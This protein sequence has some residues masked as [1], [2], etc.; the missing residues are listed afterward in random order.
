MKFIEISKD[1]RPLWQLLVCIGLFGAV[2]N[3]EEMQSNKIELLKLK[4]F[5]LK[6]FVYIKL[7][8]WILYILIFFY[9]YK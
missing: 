9:L 7:R 5:I 3:P 4:D 8:R 2:T 6:H 1:T